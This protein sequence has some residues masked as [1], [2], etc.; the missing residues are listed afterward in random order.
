MPESYEDGLRKP[1]IYVSL[2]PPI[3]SRERVATSPVGDEC[4]PFFDKLVKFPISRDQLIDKELVFIMHDCDKTR[5]ADISG[6]A[7]VKLDDVL[8]TSNKIEV[9]KS[10]W[11]MNYDATTIQLKTILN[12]VEGSIDIHVKI[13]VFLSHQQV[14]VD[15]SKQNVND[16]SELLLSLNYL[17]QAERL[18]ISIMRARNLRTDKNTRVKVSLT[19]FMMSLNFQKFP[20]QSYLQSE[21]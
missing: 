9:R 19:S 3:D 15:F 14:F 4:H 11:F 10:L 2:Y 16:S 21:F 17:S 12:S 13:V 6:E 18:V 1:T 5:T 7:R 20:Q 8:K